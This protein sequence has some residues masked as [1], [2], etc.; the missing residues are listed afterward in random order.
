MNLEDIVR[1]KDYMVEGNSDGLYYNKEMDIYKGK[2]YRIIKTATCENATVFRLGNLDDTI[3]TDLG[4]WF[5]LEKWL[6][7]A[8]TRIPV[9]E[10]L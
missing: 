7:P 6:E 9:E 8:E 3:D 10:L 5:W 2:T 1:V 4:R